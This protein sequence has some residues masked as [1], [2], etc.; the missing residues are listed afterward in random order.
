MSS[1]LHS[2]IYRQTLSN[3]LDEISFD[4]K[5]ALDHPLLQ[6]NYRFLLLV[7]LSQE[8][9]KE[10][11]VVELGRI[12]EEWERVVQEG[13]F[14][15]LL[16][17]HEILEGKSADL[18]GDAGLS[19]QTRRSIAEHVEGCLLRGET[20]RSSTPSSTSSAGA[21]MIGRPMRPP[22]SRTGSSHPRS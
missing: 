11:A 20:G 22:C 15:F 10:S 4:Q 18:A 9:Q 16:D 14:E 13:D 7:L 6:R 19:T 5:L 12:A 2:E 8:G 3:L 17:L 1:Q 21:S